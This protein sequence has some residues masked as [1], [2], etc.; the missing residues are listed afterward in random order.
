MVEMP[1][2]SAGTL[3]GVDDVGDRDAASGNVEPARR[4][5]IGDGDR[6]VT[7]YVR[8]CARCR[9]VNHSSVYGALARRVARESD[10]RCPRCAGVAAIWVEVAE[11]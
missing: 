9:T 6:S 7:F 5:V 11:P 4:A 8:C 10:W 1:G 3:G 2:G